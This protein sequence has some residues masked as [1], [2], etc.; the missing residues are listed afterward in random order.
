MT[1]KNPNKLFPL[2]ITTN[3]AKIKE[4]YIDQSGFRVV[5]DMPNYLHVAYG[6]TDGP[7]LSFMLP[8]AFPGGQLYPAFT[9]EGVIVSIPTPNADEK[10]AALKAKNIE[11]LSEPTEKP[12]GWRSFFVRDPAGLIL[13]FFHV[14]KA[15][16]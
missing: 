13:D 12:W 3:L 4:F 10:Y 8:D 6:E 7:E 11:M 16:P 15:H 1:L 14:V 9:G 5:F 2:I